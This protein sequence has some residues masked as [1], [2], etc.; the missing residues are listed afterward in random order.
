MRNASSRLPRNSARDYAI[1]MAS[2]PDKKGP[3]PWLRAL[4]HRDLPMRFEIDGAE[5]SL[6]KTF[7]HDF[8]AATGLY[9]GD[10][11]RVVLKVG[12]QAS[13]YGIPLRWVG[14]VLCRRETRLL[15]KT[16]HLD[17]VP[18]WVGAWEDTG[19]IHEFIAGQPLRKGDDPADD[20][21]P[22]LESLLADMHALDIAYVDIEKRENVLVGDDGRPWL[23]DFQIGWDR[24]GWFA[25]RWVLRIL[26]RSDR[27]HLLKHWRRLRPDQLDDARRR[28]ASRPP[29]WVAG[30]R[31]LFRPITRLRR[32][33]L[34]RLGAR[35]TTKGRSPG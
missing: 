13:A 11:G 5:Y 26:Q 12:R 32:M 31:L 17:G 6:A 8:F 2:T 28:E 16:H 33:I 23:F 4:G 29:F 24:S 10:A 3:P 1:G 27:Y 14:R 34:V 22:R 30:H 35:S 18:R 7:K 15:R 19:L 21:F 9:E 25:T 20:F